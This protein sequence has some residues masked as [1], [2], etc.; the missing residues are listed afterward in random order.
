MLFALVAAAVSC[1]SPNSE[2]ADLPSYKVINPLIKDATHTKDHVAQIRAYQ[3]VEIRSRVGGFINQVLVDEG[4]LVKKG[5]VLV[6]LNNASFVQRLQKAKV[7]TQRAQAKL[8]AA[9][10]KLQGSKSLL[11]KGFISKPEYDLDDV[12]VQRQKAALEK[13]RVNEANAELRLSYTEIRAPFDGI[14][15]RIPNKTGSLVDRGDLITTIS[16]NHKMFAY[17]NVSEV[18]YLEYINEEGNQKTQEVTLALANGRTYPHRG[19]IETTESEFDPNT[20]TLA[21]RATFPNPDNILKHGATGKVRISSTLE[22][23]VLIPQK[24]TFDRQEYLCVYVLDSDNVVRAQPVTPI[25]HVHG[26]FAVTGISGQDKIIYE[27][28]QHVTEGDKISPALIPFPE[29]LTH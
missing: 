5:Q 14:I 2:T 11:D 7:E 6:T 19:I 21:F 26:L 15:N 18:D 13:A 27:G 17:F 10:V 3:N 9:E 24:T 12:K 29:T 20:G 4:Q 25:L 23:A 1:S 16:N 22:N 28:L 8:T